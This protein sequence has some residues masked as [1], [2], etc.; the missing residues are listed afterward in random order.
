MDSLSH[1][2]SSGSAL[3]HAAIDAASPPHTKLSTVFKGRAGVAAAMTGEM[4]EA[5]RSGV[6]PD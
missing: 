1:I 3:M 5:K 4:R 2:E 6:T